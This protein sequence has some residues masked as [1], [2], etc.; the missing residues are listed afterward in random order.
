MES[1]LHAP[2]DAE[3]LVPLQKANPEATEK[4]Q[5]DESYHPISPFGFVSI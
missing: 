5:D 4:I 3:S 2:K 1:T